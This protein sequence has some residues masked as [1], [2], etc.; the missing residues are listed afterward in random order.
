MKRDSTINKIKNVNRY[1]ADKDSRI[2]MRKWTDEEYK[3]LDPH[4]HIFEKYWSYSCPICNFIPMPS[5]NKD[6]VQRAAEM[7]M[8]RC[9]NSHKCVVKYRN[10]EL[11]CLEFRDEFLEDL[12]VW[13][14]KQECY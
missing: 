5:Y 4:T 10:H 13:V 8:S 11:I 9:G 7:H 14:N 1:W 2:I 3:I 12:N 6:E